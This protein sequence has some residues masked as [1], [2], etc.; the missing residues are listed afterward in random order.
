MGYVR[1]FGPCLWAVVS[2]V[3]VAGDALAGSM[4]KD[5]ER[6][7]PRIAQRGTTVEVMI[8]GLFLE[9]PR[10]LIF[11]KPG[12]RA[13]KVEPLPKLEHP[14]GAGQEIRQRSGKGTL[15]IDPRL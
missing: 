3:G 5:I 13:V 1:H 7:R 14:I 4:Q 8:Q 15:R 9:Q 11:H 2:A 10:D 6:V 12:I